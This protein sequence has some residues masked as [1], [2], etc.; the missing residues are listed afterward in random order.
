M[1]PEK[2]VGMMQSFQEGK[3][4]D[5]GSTN[6][7]GGP[8]G[9]LSQDVM[10]GDCHHEFCV[11]PLSV[12][13]IYRATKPAPAPPPAPDSEVAE[14]RRK[15]LDAEQAWE[16]LQSKSV[17]NLDIERDGQHKVTLVELLADFA[18]GVVIGRATA[19]PPAPKSVAKFWRDYWMKEPLGN[20][21]GKQAEPWQWRMCHFAEAYA[22]AHA[23]HLQAELE[24]VR[25]EGVEAVLDLKDQIREMKIRNGEDFRAAEARC[26]VLKAAL[27]VLIARYHKL[28]KRFSNTG[29]TWNEITAAERALGDQEEK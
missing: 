4:P 21:G 26:R 13:R 1:S 22:A 11:S 10:C 20:V 23:A 24:Q 3:C 12:E 15:Q 16:Y 17:P 18:N 8:R 19:P 6:L 29:V 27:R 25:K 9:G 5:C 28:P 14:L 2:P 7:L